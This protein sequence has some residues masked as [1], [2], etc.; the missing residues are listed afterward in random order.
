MA[1]TAERPM[2]IE[3]LPE[4]FPMNR[5]ARN[6]CGRRQ[7]GGAV[8]ARR[9]ASEWGRAHRSLERPEAPAIPKGNG[10][11]LANG[12]HCN[13]FSPG[14]LALAAQSFRKVGEY[15]VRMHGKPHG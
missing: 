14:M 1:R 6:E 4:A 3:V 12:A 5:A 7:S 10:R 9:M 13:R 15:H 8:S 2:R 11:P